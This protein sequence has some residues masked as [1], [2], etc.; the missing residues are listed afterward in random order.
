MP[1]SGKHR[2]RCHGTF[3]STEEGS[4]GGEVQSNFHQLFLLHAKDNRYIIHYAVK[5]MQVHRP[6]HS[7]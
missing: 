5:N 3:E 2:S 6:S 7:N 4:G 1:P